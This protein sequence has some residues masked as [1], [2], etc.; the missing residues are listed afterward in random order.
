MKGPRRTRTASPGSECSPPDLNCKCQM[1]GPCRIRTA[2]GCCRTRT[3]S[4]GSNGPGS[5]LQALDRSGPCRTQLQALDRSGPCRTST[6]SARSQWSPTD[7]NSKPRIRVVPARLQLQA[8]H[9]S[10]P[11]RTRTASGGS[12]SSPLDRK[13]EN[14]RRECQWE[15]Q[16]RCQI[17]CQKR[18]QI[19]CQ[20][21][22]QI[23]CQNRYQIE[24]QVKCQM[25]YLSWKGSPDVK[26]LIPNNP[27]TPEVPKQP[28][29][30]SALNKHN[31]VE[32]IV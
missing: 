3:A 16:S 10:G 18:R 9:R 29:E 22:W 6:A 14:A 25:E 30:R 20:K 26:Q 19:E 24:C 8:L 5:Q 4:L 21:K 15:C 23:E 31:A 11:R 32:N 13:R 2:I 1:Q 12:E 27:H 28:L 17:E 7:P